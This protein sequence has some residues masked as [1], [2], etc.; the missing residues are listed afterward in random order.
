MSTVAD[1]D[2]IRR[3]ASMYVGNTS[4]RGI[5]QLLFEIVHNAI[6]SARLENVRHVSVMIRNDG[7]ATISDDRQGNFFWKAGAL[8]TVPSER[9]T[10]FEASIHKLNRPKDS[11]SEVS[12][13]SPRVGL[14]IVN[15]LSAWFSIE[16]ICD[17]IRYLQNYKEGV[18]VSKVE[19][20]ACDEP[21][22]TRICFEPDPK[23]FT[24]VSFQRDVVLDRLRQ[25]AFLNPAVEIAFHDHRNPN[26]IW[27][28]RGVVDFVESLNHEFPTV[29]D[30]F[31]WEHIDE[32]DVQYSIALQYQTV[33][34][35]TRILGFVNN[36]AVPAGS[37][38][39]SFVRTV[40]HAL[41]EFSQ[42]HGLAMTSSLQ[43]NVCCQSL[44]AIVSMFHK[45]PRFRGPTRSELADTVVERVIEAH[46]GAAFSQF[47]H[48]GS[49]TG[50]K[51]LR[52]IAA[53]SKAN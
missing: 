8:S 5:H 19:W 17:G 11:T 23:V 35:Q 29:H 38:V 3:R 36:D 48:I 16:V 41:K 46:F 49:E 31:S 40:T 9:A 4:S 20:Q 25:F 7:S 13:H 53:L 10:A 50:P 47:L 14:P 26:T 15:Y 45:S 39:S 43:S 52:H 21:N 37:H 18:A 24:S 44:T 1:R 51:I 32:R 6:D 12:D 28:T 22:G 30:V 42:H 27:S 34:W 33:V 2:A